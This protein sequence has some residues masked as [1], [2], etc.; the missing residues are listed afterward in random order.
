[1]KKIVLLM[2]ISLSPLFSHAQGVSDG[3]KIKSIVSLSD[4]LVFTVTGNTESDR[5]ECASTKRFAVQ[6][7]S[8]HVPV[9]ISAFNNGKKLG[10]IRGLGSCTQSLDSEDLKWIEVVK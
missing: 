2:V 4:V 9:I 7:D 6:G 5:P 3:G 1:M 8:T 10:S